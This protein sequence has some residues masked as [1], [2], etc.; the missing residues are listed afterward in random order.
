M[1][2]E[3]EEVREETEERRG[4]RDNPDVTPENCQ[5]W[6]CKMPDDFEVGFLVT[7]PGRLDRPIAFCIADPAE[8]RTEKYARE[9]AHEIADN[10]RCLEVA[11]FF[12]GPAIDLRHFGKLDSNAPMPRWVYGLQCRPDVGDG[13][14]EYTPPPIADSCT[15]SLSR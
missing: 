2:P 11:V 3:V 15:F 10:P 7:E 1:I 13:N 4:S 14:Y 9:T 6:Q 5:V 12:Q 8:G